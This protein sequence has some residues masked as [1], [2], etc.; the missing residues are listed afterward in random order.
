MI[1][2]SNGDLL[3]DVKVFSSSESR[4]VATATTFT[5]EFLGR[6][7]PEDF[8]FITKEMLDDSNAAKV[9]FSR[10]SVDIYGTIRN[11]LIL[12]KESFS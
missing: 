6:D 10:L 9:F 11:K 2:S 12:S 5:K 1:L 4:V 8:I 3:E 7:I